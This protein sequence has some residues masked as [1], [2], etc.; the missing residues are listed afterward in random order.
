ML[1][2]GFFFEGNQ[3]VY[4]TDADAFFTAAGITDI[5]QERA[6]NQLVI[7]YK[8]AG[9]W[10]KMVAIYPFVGGTSTTH[11]YNLKNPALYQIA[12][13]GTVTHNANGV[14]GDGSTGYGNTGIAPSAALSLNN[15]HLAYMSRTNNTGIAYAIGVVEAVN[16]LFMGNF[17]S[18]TLYAGMNV[19]GALVTASIPNTTG[20]FL[21]NR[22]SSTTASIFR[23]GS[24]IVSALSSSS[25]L[26]TTNIFVLANNNSGTP[27][28]RSTAN[29]SFISIGEGLTST[30]IADKY[31]ADAAF[32]AALVR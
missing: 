16:S 24:S 28:Y 15:C 29:Y 6:I 31:T 9:I 32:Q 2:Q 19:N 7:G 10:S 22:T 4:D 18:S 11:S 14:T 12:W 3:T 25:A 21:A 1:N 30:E 20:E 13:S 23:N 8:A 26:P 5:T 27:S 17:S